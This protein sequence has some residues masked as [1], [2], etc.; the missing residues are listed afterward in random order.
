M[1]YKE[2]CDRCEESLKTEVNQRKVIAE[3]ENEKKELLCTVS[4]LQNEVTLLNS[5]LYDMADSLR[6]M[7]NG[8]DMI[9]EVGDSEGHCQSDNKQRRVYAEKF[10][11]IERKKMITMSNHMLQHPGRHDEPPNKSQ[12]T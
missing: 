12:S 7:K 4:Q 9:K 5:K 8:A 2:T 3:L 11:P 1:S 10:L 6:R